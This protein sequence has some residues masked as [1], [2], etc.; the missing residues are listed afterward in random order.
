M[1]ELEQFSTVL[2]G[3]L[4]FLMISYVCYFPYGE[5]QRKVVTKVEVDRKLKEWA[6]TGTG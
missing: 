3:F 1:S 5:R 2:Y 4:Q 6:L